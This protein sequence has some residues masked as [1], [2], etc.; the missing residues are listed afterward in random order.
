[1]NKAKQVLPTLLVLAAV[2]D[3]ACSQTPELSADPYAHCEDLGDLAL[4]SFSRADAELRMSSDGLTPND[5]SASAVELWYYG[6]A[7]RCNE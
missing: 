4:L 5:A 2:L 3:I 7:L 6:A 1:M